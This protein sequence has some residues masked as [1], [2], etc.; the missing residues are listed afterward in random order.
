MYVLR[1]ISE[2]KK[3]KLKL[4]KVCAGVLY[5]I[6]PNN[7]EQNCAL[8]LK[9]CKVHFE[10]T[11]QLKQQSNCGL[12]ELKTEPSVGLFAA[13]TFWETTKG[14]LRL[15]IL[16]LSARFFG[17]VLFSSKRRGPGQL[18]VTALFADYAR[19][20]FFLKTFYGGCE[21]PACS[22]SIWIIVK[23]LKLPLFFVQ[24]VE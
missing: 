14:I 8:E 22:A 6:S 16:S 4:N 12:S 7:L 21:R 3:I 11:T 19:A 20:I 13:T 2:I 24:T 17:Y 9:F 18:L 5:S 1:F 15:S 10:N 23:S